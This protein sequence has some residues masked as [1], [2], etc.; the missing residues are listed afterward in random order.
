MNI[1]GFISDYY[2]SYYA[3]LMNSAFLNNSYL[4]IFT[5]IR[6]RRQSTVSLV[7][8]V[9]LLTDVDGCVELRAATLGSISDLLPGEGDVAPWHLIQ[10]I[11]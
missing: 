11:H 1:S 10:V 6:E 5:G 2:L 9:Q 3:V 8:V 7:I 4:W